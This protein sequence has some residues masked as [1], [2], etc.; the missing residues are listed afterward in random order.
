MRVIPGRVSFAG[1]ADVDS[2]LTRSL[3]LAGACVLLA[4]FAGSEVE[5]LAEVLLVIVMGDRK[6]E[7]PA[8]GDALEGEESRVAAVDLHRVVLVCT[9]NRQTI[10]ELRNASLQSHPRPGNGMAR[11][12]DHATTYHRGRIEAEVEVVNFV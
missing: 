4:A 8:G 6:P 3:V 2:P 10:S 12:V 7:R 11:R 5:G 9:E 1:D